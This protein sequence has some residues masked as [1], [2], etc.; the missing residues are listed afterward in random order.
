MT[1]PLIGIVAKEKDIRF[2]GWSVNTT[3]NELRAALVAAGAR[4]IALLP[5]HHKRFITPFPDAEILSPA[6]QSD[7][8]ETLSLCDGVVL[9]GGTA[10]FRYE[11]AVVLQALSLKIPF[12]GIC[13]GL[14]TMARAV[15]GRADLIPEPHNHYHPEQQTTHDIHLNPDSL[16]AR[17]VGQTHFSVN[18]IHH[19]T[20]YDTGLYRPV[21]TTPDGLTEAVEGPA[22]TFHI[23]VHFHPELDWETNPASARLFRAFVTAADEYRRGKGC[24]I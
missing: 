24:Q 22:D 15:G 10:V 2:H 11:E 12:L 3:S 21:G 8:N 18:S 19:N 16:L 23:G 5:P 17:I 6:E 13:A 4:V 1:K 20:V 14:N 7:L 9:Q